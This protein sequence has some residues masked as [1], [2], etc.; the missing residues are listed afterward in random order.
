MNRANADNY[1]AGAGRESSLLPSGPTSKPNGLVA[2]KD[3]AALVPMPELLSTMGI[4]VNTRSRRA[5]CLLH[6][7][8]NVTALSWR[9][10]GVWF[11][12][13]CGKGGDKFSLV[14]EVRKCS[15]LDALRFL[16]ALAG[17]EWSSLNTAE[18]HQQ[19]AEAKRKARRV[20]AGSQKLQRLEQYLL[21]AARDELLSLHR[22]R[23]NA[24]TR[25]AAIRRGN[26]PRFADEEAVAWDA[27]AL[28]AGQELAVSAEY[29][30]LAFGAPTM[31]SRY[32][33]HPEQRRTLVEEVLLAGAVVD[34]RGRVMELTP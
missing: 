33:L 20:K 10:D 11:C 17:I 18:V 7:G 2:A 25:L 13:S 22:L 19:L 26:K 1:P 8:T 16:A 5:P 30:L 9:D 23:R 27:L 21:L 14:Q 31:R 4:Q 34:E 29:L 3:V 32:A 6:G 15:F 12:F 28:V 24:G